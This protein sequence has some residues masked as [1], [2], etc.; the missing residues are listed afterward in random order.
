LEFL[1]D[2]MMAV[3]GAPEPAADHARSAVECGRDIVAAVRGLRLGDPG[4]PAIGVSVGIATGV[5]FVGNVRAAD[6][7]IYTAIGDV[8][9]LA[10]R[11]EGLTRKLDASVAIDGATQA[12]AG[13]AAAGFQHHGPTLVRG[14]SR[15]VDVY[16]LP[17]ADATPAG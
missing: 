1:G 12:G 4:S 11:L 3:F 7:F 15:V 10:S 14:R 8:P 2:G 13:D 6:R 17:Q 16:F 9:N 5:A